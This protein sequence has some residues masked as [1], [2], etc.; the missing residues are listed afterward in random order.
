MKGTPMYIPRKVSRTVFAGASLLAVILAGSP[1]AVGAT[2]PVPS[3]APIDA[4]TYLVNHT[5]GLVDAATV[6]PN[7]RLWQET[8]SQPM[9]GLINSFPDIVGQGAWDEKS[10][11]A[12]QDYYTG[13]DPAQEAAFLAAVSRVDALVPSQLKL[14][15]KPVNWSDR[16]R[17]SLVRQISTNP[18]KWTPYFGSAPQG[19]GLDRDGIVHV[20]LTDPAKVSSAPAKSGVLP[21]GTP[22]IAEPP[23]VVEWQVGRTTDVS[24]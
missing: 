15:W 17:S 13:A 24:H 8:M 18:E 19:G 10:G 6:P 2:N 22:F 5:P 23:P 21:D 4:K 9:G 7:Q 20:F 1:L 11:T 14:V 12:T 16:Q 3:P